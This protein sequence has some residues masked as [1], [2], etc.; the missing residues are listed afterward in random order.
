MPLL[1]KSVK[2]KLNFFIILLFYFFLF[3]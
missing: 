2:I 1:S 3:K